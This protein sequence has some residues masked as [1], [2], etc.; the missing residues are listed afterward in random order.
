MLTIRQA[1]ALLR[2]DE[3]TVNKYVRFGRL[4]GIKVAGQWQICPQ[5]VAAMAKK[6]LQQGKTPAP[7]HPWRSF[8]LPGS[9]R[10]GARTDA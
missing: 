2:R 9:P 3:S 6:P 4:K 10:F 5:S 8:R 1:A 7:A